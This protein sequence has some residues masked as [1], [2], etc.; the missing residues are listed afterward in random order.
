MMAWEGPKTWESTCTDITFV[1]R[2]IDIF[3]F[4]NVY[5]HGTHII[6]ASIGLSLYHTYIIIVIINTAHRL[7]WHSNEMPPHCYSRAWCLSI[8]VRIAAL[9]SG[10][11]AIVIRLRALECIIFESK[12]GRLPGGHSW[13]IHVDHFASKS[14]VIRIDA[15]CRCRCKWRPL[16]LWT[17]TVVNVWSRALDDAS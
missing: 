8:L 16:G 14:L 3:T 17:A 4:Y 11:D 2:I 12:E 13:W 15:T 10:V 7:R 1:F 9:G 5:T 6:P